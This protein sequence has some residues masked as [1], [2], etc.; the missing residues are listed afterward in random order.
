MGVETVTVAC[1]M[2]RGII[3]RL[4][5]MQPHFEPIQA[6]GVR[7]TVKAHEVE[8]VVLKGYGVAWGKS[9][10]GE[11]TGGYALTPNVPKAFW[12]AWYEQNKTTELVTHKLI[13]AHVDKERVADKSREFEKNRDGLE[14]LDPNKLPKGIQTLN[15]KDT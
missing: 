15:R 11:E 14:P 9:S 10:P 8:R 2:P 7:E 4:F 3:L 1:K 13:F 6:G 12:D 5:V